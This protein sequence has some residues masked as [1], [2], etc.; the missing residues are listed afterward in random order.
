MKY[1]DVPPGSVFFFEDNWEY[2]KKKTQNGHRD[3]RDGVSGMMPDDIPV[4]SVLEL[5]KY[6]A[7]KTTAQELRKLLISTADFSMLDGSPC[8]CGWIEKHSGTCKHIR[9]ITGFTPI[10]KEQ[11]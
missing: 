8:W 11:S 10:E 1:K 6:P 3:L 7:L 5:A 9:D 2:P 4:I